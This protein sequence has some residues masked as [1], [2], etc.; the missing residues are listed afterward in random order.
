[1]ARGQ[2]ISR[3]AAES[4]S[5]MIEQRRDVEGLRTHAGRDWELGCAETRP[6]CSHSSDRRCAVFGTDA[7]T[8]TRIWQGAGRTRSVC[9]TQRPTCHI[10]HLFDA[11]ALTSTV[12]RCLS[13]A[14]FVW[15][16]C[17]SQG[18]GG[19]LA[20]GVAALPAFSVRGAY[21]LR[22]GPSLLMAPQCRKVLLA[23]GSITWIL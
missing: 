18:G 4:R 3:S 8:T 1:M 13:A 2:R 19:G 12:F 14:A 17:A 7:G 16:F 5:Q 23:V 21:R 11:G 22:G 15:R 20:K 10:G 9:T 6:L